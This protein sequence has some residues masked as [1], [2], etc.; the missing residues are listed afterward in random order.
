MRNAV[1]A[2]GLAAVVSGCASVAPEQHNGHVYYGNHGHSIP[3][4]WTALLPE[5]V[6]TG[7][8]MQAGWA[9]HRRSGVTIASGDTWY[10]GQGQR[11]KTRQEVEAELAAQ[12]ASQD[13][14]RNW[15]ASRRS[16]MPIS[17]PTTEVFAQEP[18]GTVVSESCHV[19]EE[20]ETPC[21]DDGASVVSAGVKSAAA[22]HASAPVHQETFQGAQGGYTNWRPAPDA[23]R[24]GGVNRRILFSALVSG[25]PYPDMDFKPKGVVINGNHHSLAYRYDTS[26]MSFNQY[27]YLKVLFERLQMGHPRVIRTAVYSEYTTGTAKERVL[28]NERMKT[29]DLVIGPGKSY[30]N[31]RPIF[32]DLRPA[33]PGKGTAKVEIEVGGRYELV[34]VRGGEVDGD[35]LKRANDLTHEIGSD[36]VYIHPVGSNPELA[37]AAQVAGKFFRD[38][39][40]KVVVS[41]QQ[42]GSQN[43]LVVETI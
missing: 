25:R 13:S 15:L 41:K 38:L 20:R 30:D 24:L 23:A 12:A 14:M 8:S 21:L 28:G 10:H 1:L 42:G 43:A 39:G 31:D 26:S 7:E 6:I 40:Y 37:I 35:D 27:Q 18:Q 5:S 29:L 33:R 2:I 34:R 19:V 3:P 36:Q 11:W 22:T 16:V 17:P 32:K 9:P 4:S